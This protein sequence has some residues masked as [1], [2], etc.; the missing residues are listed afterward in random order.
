[1][2]MGELHLEVLVDRMQ[3][4]YNVEAT[5]GKPQVAYRETVTKTVENYEYRHVKQSG[6]SGQF[7]VIKLRVEPNPG[8]GFEFADEIT[9]GRVPRE[10]IAPTGQGA[11]AGLESGILAG[12]PMV[13]VKVTLVDGQYHDVDSSEMAFK[14]AGQAGVKEAAQKAGAV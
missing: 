2:G 1:S 3:R 10:Y 7:A 4:E 9:G 8:A 6:G 13:D 11:E 5:I 14:I 12:F